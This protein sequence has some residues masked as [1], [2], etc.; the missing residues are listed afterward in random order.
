[1]HTVMQHISFEEDWDQ[2]KLKQFIQQLILKEI[3]THEQSEVIDLRG[4]EQFFHSDAYQVIK[5]LDKLN[6]KY[7]LV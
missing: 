7:H 1:M 2:S 5:K 3:L 4:I 6:E